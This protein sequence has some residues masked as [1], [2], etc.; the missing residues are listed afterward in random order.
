MTNKME[1]AGKR[2]IT[3][4]DRVHITSRNY[5]HKKLILYY[6]NLEHDDLVN[7][8]RLFADSKCF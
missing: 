5:L 7:L 6:F 3:R 1:I 2:S 8:Y 4:F